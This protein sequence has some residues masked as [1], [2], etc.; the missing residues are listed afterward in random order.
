MSNPYLDDELTTVV[1]TAWGMVVDSADFGF[2]EEA[3]EAGGFGVLTLNVLREIF[4]NHKIQRTLVDGYN[5]LF[6]REDDSLDD[7]D[8]LD[9]EEEDLELGSTPEDDDEW[10]APKPIQEPLVVDLVFPD[11]PVVDKEEE[12]AELPDME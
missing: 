6:T 8:D 4:G 2:E 1:M 11:K 12:C 3:R 5:D 7:Y 9:D 10:P